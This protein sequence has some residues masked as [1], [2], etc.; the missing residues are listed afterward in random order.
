MKA[1]GYWKQWLVSSAIVLG[2]F[3]GL[4]ALLSE[5][6]AEA[7][8]VA[9]LTLPAITVTDVVTIPG[10]TIKIPAPTVTAPGP[11]VTLPGKTVTARPP[12]TGSE[13]SRSAPG[14]TET[15]IK[16]VRPEPVTETVTET[17]TATPT[18][19]PTQEPDIVTNVPEQPDPE[20]RV[21]TIVKGVLGLLAVAA[22][23]VVL[24]FV[25]YRLG[26]G[27][28]TKREVE[29]QRKWIRKLLDQD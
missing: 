26:Y 10:P 11:T 18:G 27:D 5:D 21:R 24:F 25:G 20:T 8:P 19:Q 22:L 16:T 1:Y 15:V 12:E 14:G 29:S 4:P 28:G 23:G 9:D 7:Q 6:S 13:N 2:V 3:F 17:V